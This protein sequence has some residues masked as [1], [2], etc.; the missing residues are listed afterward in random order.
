MRQNGRD[1]I[2]LYCES[3]T[4]KIYLSSLKKKQ[5]LIWDESGPFRR[6]LDS[7]SLTEGIDYVFFN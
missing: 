1:I 4:F 3:K 2:V 7:L 6:L 5:E